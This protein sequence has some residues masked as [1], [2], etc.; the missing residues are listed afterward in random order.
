MKYKLIFVLL[1]FLAITSCQPGNIQ[2]L[3]DGVVIRL[4]KKTATDASLVRLQVITDDIIR[5]TASPVDSFST[6][7]SLMIADNNLS[8]VKWEMVKSDDHVIITTS[9]LNAS[10]SVN[11]GEV[12]FTDKDGNV[13]LKEN[14]GGGKTFVPDSIEG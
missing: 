11:T 8:P 4:H 14:E 12:N 1:A 13:I 7:K 2:K 6:K 5:V 3:S 10:V 9:K